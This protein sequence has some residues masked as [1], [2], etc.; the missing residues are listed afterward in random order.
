VARTS[1]SELVERL[2]LTDDEALAVFDVDPLSA[3]SGRLEHLPE[4]PILGSLTAAA[5]EQVGQAVLKRWLRAAGPGG[6][7]IDLLLQ[8]DFQAFELALEGLIERG[9]VLRGGGPSA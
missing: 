7:P 2:G 4:L 6:R 9:L 8:R 1:F 5:V 3:I